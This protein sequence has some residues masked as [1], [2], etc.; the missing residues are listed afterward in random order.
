MEQEILFYTTKGNYGFMTNFA[1][2]FQMVDGIMYPTNEHYYQS[3]K[4]NNIALKMWIANAPNPYAAMMA[5]RNLRPKEMVENWEEIKFDIM[6][7]GLRAKFSQNIIAKT[8]LFA[9]NDV[10]IHE[11][12]PTDLIW[13]KLGQDMLGKLIMQVRDELRL[14]KI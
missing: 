10:I 7:K 9:T 3:E 1:R 8:K 6:L 14:N 13:G 12:S 5:G 11:D 4:A 2:F